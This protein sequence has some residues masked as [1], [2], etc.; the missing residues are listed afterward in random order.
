MVGK[1]TRAQEQYDVLKKKDHDQELPF[2]T[3]I[4]SDHVIRIV[5]QVFNS[6]LDVITDET[7][8]NAAQVI[9]M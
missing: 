6:Y 9:H 7:I 5:L 4:R 3:E 2:E 1:T 8:L